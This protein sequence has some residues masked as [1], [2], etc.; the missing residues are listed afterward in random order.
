MQIPKTRL[1]ELLDGSSTLEEN[2]FCKINTVLL[3][4]IFMDLISSP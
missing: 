2:M 1:N 4:E 3:Y